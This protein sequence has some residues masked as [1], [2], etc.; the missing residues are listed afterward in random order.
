MLDKNW[1]KEFAKPEPV[2]LFLI[3]EQL[4][5][6]Y[7]QGSVKRVL[8]CAK[9]LI[10]HDGCDDDALL[11][12]AEAGQ[13]GNH[14]EA[15]ELGF[16]ELHK[17][18]PDNPDY[19]KYLVES[20]FSRGDFH[21]ALQIWKNAHCCFELPEYT[22]YL[23][24]LT[25]KQSL[26]SELEAVSKHVFSLE[27]GYSEEELFSSASQ[28][29]DL[30]IGINDFEMA[31][32]LLSQL[33][34]RQKVDAS[35]IIEKFYWIAA[36]SPRYEYSQL[37]KSLKKGEDWQ[38][39]LLAYINWCTKARN[40]VVASKSLLEHLPE[41]AN[42]SNSASLSIAVLV[43]NQQWQRAKK[44]IDAT[45]NVDWPDFIVK[46]VAEAF[47]QTLDGEPRVEAIIGLPTASW[48]A[49][50]GCAAAL[51]RV[52]ELIDLRTQYLQNAL[53]LSPDNSSLLN[54]LGDVLYLKEEYF[55]AKDYFFRAI[56]NDQEGD[57]YTYYNLALTLKKIGAN[58]QSFEYYK[59]ALSL[60]PEKWVVWK[61]VGN[62]MV[63]SSTRELASACFRL[64]LSKSEED[65][66]AWLKLA[67]IC[68]AD[69]KIE[70][71][72]LYIRQAEKHGASS[73]NLCYAKAGIQ[74]TLGNASASRMIYMPILEDADVPIQ[75]KLSALTNMLFSANYDPELTA[76]ELYQQYSWVK[77][78]LPQQ[79]YF[80]WHS[81]S[82]HKKIRIGYVSSDFK[83]HA[84][85]FFIEPFI[86]QH[87]KN[88]VEI[89]AYSGVQ[90]EDEVTERLKPMFDHWHYVTRMSD[91]D[92]AELIR[93]D[94]IDILVDLSGHTGGHRLS[95]FALKPAPIQMSWLGYGYT[96][97]L[98]QVDYFLCD[99]EVAPEGSERLFS[100]K[101]LR[102]PR[103]QYSYLPAQRYRDYQPTFKMKLEGEPIL[104]GSATRA[105]RINEKL[106]SV[107]S[108]I[109]ER[110]PCAHFRLDNPC[111]SDPY[112]QNE[113]RERFKKAGFDLDRVWI[114]HKPNYF[115]SLS[116][117]DICLDCFPHN[118][119]TTIFDMLW[120]GT[121]VVT[122]RDR[123][124]VGRIG[125][126]IIHGFGADDWIANTEE[127]YVEIV[128]NLASDRQKL[129]EIKSSMRERFLNSELCDGK[130][131]CQKVEEAYFWALEEYES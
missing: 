70:E 5:L 127:E 75:S 106:L 10:K 9:F 64:Y 12:L 96:T 3:N 53:L 57:F 26:K 128:V 87:N 72:M 31:L 109:M 113:M 112:A 36:N 76:E 30:S 99:W 39:L 65:F 32:G 8:A 15:A 129:Y 74:T 11:K 52:P 116:E 88:V 111:Y 97:G 13:K 126:S 48:L 100:E 86:E 95:V 123:P 94:E 22:G 27:A 78:L 38:A 2:A 4:E 16:K 21:G 51:E 98:P 43:L 83:R 37:I 93:K 63:E 20:L 91:I 23:D 115:E 104:I 54:D 61:S 131:F 14:Q 130:D 19:T 81:P 124:S 118:S 85:S 67:D 7:K 42:D 105:L 84:C 66:S 60:E 110:L 49:L 33:V 73:L 122:K 50:W 68:Q 34:A 125:V 102:L 92:L 117:M 59:I 56:K 58:K 107:W 18:E 55:E 28:C 90:L 46:Y 101:P 108:D 120:C 82:K 69:Q 41:I 119:G 29:V 79:K 103:A 62:Y 44:I 121:P 71:S 24:V 45:P 1:R 47:V 17:R 40:P 25:E 89:Y 114:G 77:R 6:A 80:E 35:W